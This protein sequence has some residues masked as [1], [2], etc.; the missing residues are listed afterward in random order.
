METFTGEPPSDGVK[1]KKMRSYYIVCKVK[2]AVHDLSNQP[3]GQTNWIKGSVL[4]GGTL[5]WSSDSEMFSW[6]FLDHE[7]KSCEECKTAASSQSFN[8]V[9]EEKGMYFRGLPHKVSCQLW[10]TSMLRNKKV[11]SGKIDLIDLFGYPN[12]ESS[13]ICCT[14]PLYTSDALVGHAKLSIKY[15]A[16]RSNGK[17]PFLASAEEELKPVGGVEKR[18]IK[19]RL[20]VV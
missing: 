14:W 2:S 1:Q 18:T 15:E 7:C 3:V 11:A 4:D 19:F 13:S 20:Q 9:A 12:I 10:E 6:S 5:T 17:Q 16:E 8:K